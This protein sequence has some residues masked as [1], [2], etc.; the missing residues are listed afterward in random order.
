MSSSV[1][2]V[3][4]NFNSGNALAS[5]LDTLHAG[6]S[7][8]DWEA[9]VVD[10]ASSDGSERAALNRDHIRLLRTAERRVCRRGQYG[11]RGYNLGICTSAEPGLP[12]YTRLWYAPCST[13]SKG[14][15][16]VR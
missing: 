3:I 5:T 6:F 11:H 1:A 10:N 15:P 2:A 12:S 7:G 8:L 16:R 4:V 13:N 14:I 9:L